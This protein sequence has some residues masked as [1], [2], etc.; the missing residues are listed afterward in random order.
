[1]SYI[2][3]F[4][5]GNPMMASCSFSTCFHI[6]ISYD[7]PNQMQLSFNTVKH[8]VTY[9]FTHQPSPWFM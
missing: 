7:H 2:M 6:H 5:D 1:M 8:H 4:S 3:W 9:G